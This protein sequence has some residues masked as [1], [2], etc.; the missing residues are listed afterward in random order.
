MEDRQ[1]TDAETAYLRLGAFMD[2]QRS[3]K[4]RNT[5]TRPNWPTQTTLTRQLRYMKS[6]L[7]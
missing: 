2:A 3:S 5:E 7:N 4:K 1:F 6:L